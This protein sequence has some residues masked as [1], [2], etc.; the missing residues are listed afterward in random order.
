MSDAP[1]HAGERGKRSTEISSSI[2]RI[3]R[4]H[5]GRGASRSRTVMGDDFVICFLEDIYTAAERTLIDA[6]RFG[7]VQD[8]RT[9]FQEAMRG[10]FVAEV[11]RITGRT[12]V[13]FLSQVHVDPDL[14]VETFVLQ[15]Q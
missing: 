4:E 11:E 10:A 1:T 13:A 15:A 14:A 8:S 5:Y 12:V 9:I 6:G 3:H 2:A 7:A